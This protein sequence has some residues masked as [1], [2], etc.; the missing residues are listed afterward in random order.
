MVKKIPSDNTY[1]PM[2]VEQITDYLLAFGVDVA[3]ANL[4]L[5]L[6]EKNNRNDY[7]FDTDHL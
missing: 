4:V 2:H 3:I 7:S 1:L 6:I 5:K